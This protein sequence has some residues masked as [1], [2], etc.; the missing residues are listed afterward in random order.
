[1]VKFTGVF[2][3]GIAGLAMSLPAL[4]CPAKIGATLS[5]TGSY[6]TFG[7]PISNAAALAIEH[8]TAAG[9]KVGD[10]TKLEYIV[11]D[12]QTQP[13]VGVDAA[14]R[15]VDVDGVPAIVGPI[16]SGVTGPILSSVTVEKGVLMVPSASSSPTF[17]DM[18][19]E[20]KLNGLFY[21][22]QPSD[23]LQAVA[24]AKLAW[25]A[26]NRSIAIVHLNNDW[27]NNLSKQF[28]ATFK[29]LGGTIVSQVAYNAEQSSY[30]AEVNK[31]LEAKPQS[32]FIAATVIDGSKILRDWISLGGT[33]K[34]LFPLGMNDA[35]LIEQI[36]EQYLKDAW[37]VTPGA[38]QPN[39]RSV[40]Y[41]AYEKRYNLE[42]GKG[43]GPGRDTG[44][45]AAALIS[46]AMMAAKDYKSGKAIAAAMNKVTDPNGTPIAATPEDFKKAVQLLAE[47]K[48]IRYVGASG[49]MMHDKF[50]DVTTPFVGW[51][52]ENKAYVQKKNVTAQDIADIKSKTGT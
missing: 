7:P 40:F 32:A 6:A 9:W 22:V 46:L 3:A 41:Q 38:P 47:G 43:V 1:M 28:A 5:L 44:Y 33:T 12:D 52:V 35:K 51:Q 30:R 26:G 16:S 13:S 10:C 8:M 17:S 27:G 4:A 15:L 31:A 50:G 14:R 36:G 21:R 25:D 42:A 20:G 18:A 11:R 48:R 45:D 23:A 49:A 29:A 19:R 2:C 39:S 37:F 24:I 34:F